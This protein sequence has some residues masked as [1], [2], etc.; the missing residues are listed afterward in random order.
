MHHKRLE[1]ICGAFHHSLI[2]FHK[3]QHID[4]A[5]GVMQDCLC[6]YVA[7]GLYK[8]VGMKSGFLF[9]HSF[10]FGNYF[11]MISEM[12]IDIPRVPVPS[13]HFAATFNIYRPRLAIQPQSL[14]VP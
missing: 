6:E 12:L 11:H 4:T 9:P 7:P 5:I 3:I 2:A 8:L 10:L 14:P 13:Y 1:C